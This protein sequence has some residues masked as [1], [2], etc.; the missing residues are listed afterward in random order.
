MESIIVLVVLAVLAV[1]VLLLVLILSLSALRRRVA[2]LEQRLGELQARG[3]MPSAAQAAPPPPV[4]LDPAPLRRPAPPPPRSELPPALPIDTPAPWGA[5]VAEPLAAAPPPRPAAAAPATPPVT[6]ATPGLAERFL[7]AARRWFTEGNVPVKVGML[8][9]LAGFAALL[10]YASDQGW[11]RLPV[12]LRLAGIAAAALGGLV[13]GWRQRLAR[14][15]F[16]KALQGGAIGVLLLVVFAAFKQYTLISAPAAFALSALLIASMCVLAVLQDSRT[17]AVLGTLAGFLAPLWLSTGSGNHVALFSYY[18]VVNAGVFAIAWWRPWRVLNLLGFA[19][20][21]G[22]GTLWGVLSYKPEH[23]ASTEPFLLL[24]FAFYLAIPVL[25]ARREGSARWVDGSLVFGAP[26]VAFAL[27]AGLLRGERWPLALCALG[28]AALYAVL[29]AVCLRDARTRLLGQAHAVLAVGFA[30]LAVPL[31]LSAH[32][33]AG[34]FALEGAGLVWLGLRQQRALPQWSGVAL[35]LAAMVAFALA[36]P[37]P[38]EVLRA[39]ANPNFMSGLLI[40]LAGLATAWV[41][42]AHARHVPALLA[43]GWGLAWWAGI[44]GNEISR[45]VQAGAQSHVTLAVAGFTG[46]LAAEVHRRRPAAALAATTAL[47]FLLAIPL[48]I[49]QTSLAQP[50]LAGNGAW[51]WPLFAVLGARALWCLRDER[52][53]R[54]AGAAQLVW[55]VLWPTVAT[56]CLRWMGLHYQLAG[57]WLLALGTAPWLLLLGVALLRW[58]WLAAPLGDAFVPWMPWLRALAAAVVAVIWIASLRAPLSAQPLPW[59]PLLNP[60]ELTQLAALALLV[61]A[62]WRFA[63]AALAAR[64]VL[65]AAATGLVWISVAT[66]RSVHHWGGLPWRADLLSAGASQTSLTVV[67]SVLG[68]A[69]W[70]AGSRRQQR[71]LWLAGAALMALVLAKLVLVDRQHL[72]N[73]LGIGSFI[74][75]GLLC[76]LVGYIAPAPPREPSAEPQEESA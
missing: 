53:G 4:H 72:G 69:G 37:A 19:F 43:Y 60:G 65:L 51:A 23:F 42:R 54:F 64:R 46:W 1:P 29:A 21:F 45:F 13:F 22:I 15:A 32:A 25:Y 75:Y 3:A 41:W 12:E 30:T 61:H 6:P 66:L 74:A 16:G 34:V 20:T 68:V 18:A 50:P 35:Q 33:T 10:K 11:L 39:V 70:I 5:S 52:Q 17:L 55:W 7:D 67:W 62:L 59:L 48:A 44:A 24:F 8:V 73:L 28:L 9:L 49:A 71:A 57:G 38:G 56:L 36:L 63:P 27:Q 40:A 58:R 26:L 47:A 2:A 14:P 76:T 31:A